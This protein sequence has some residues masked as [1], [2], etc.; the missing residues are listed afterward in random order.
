MNTERVNETTR[1]QWLATSAAL[2]CATPL[3]RAEDNSDAPVLIKNPK[4]L[5][6]API[7]SVRTPLGIPEDYKPWITKLNNGDLLVTCFHA[8]REPFDEHAVFWRSTDGGDSWSDRVARKDIVG[9]EFAV[10]QL[11]TGSI[12]MTCHFLAQDKRNTDGYAYSKLFHSHDNGKT[13]K[14]TRVGP[15]AF[16]TKQPTNTDRN[17]FEMPDPDDPTMAI[18]CM[19]IST[20]G[21]H[22]N[23][24]SY[25]SIWTSKDGGDTWNKDWRPDTDNWDDFDG[26]FGQSYTYRSPSGKL[27]HVVRVDRRGKYWK[28]GNQQLANERGDQGD[29]MMI[30][31]S[32]DKGKTWRRLNKHGD[33]GGYGEMYPRFL[34]LNDGRLLLTFTVRSNATDGYALGL[35]GLLS[36]DDGETWDFE[37]DR[38]IIDYA[39]QGPSGGGYGNTVQL[40]DDSL[41]STYSYRGTDGKT[42]VEVIKWKLPRSRLVNP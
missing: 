37:N 39:N 9:R 26:F 3:L 23:K 32:L 13:W 11:A 21:Y 24:A 5:P 38:I 8:G 34:K 31:R 4:R 16:P 25:T 27:L 1:R 42:H 29:R 14:E 6:P 22:E 15:E 12:V 40:T 33:F 10:T 7:T 17:L 30:W 36:Y 35:R 19:G 28:L 18:A 2:A 20:S 41:V